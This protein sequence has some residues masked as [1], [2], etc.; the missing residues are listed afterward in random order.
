ME[1]IM[2]QTRPIDK[3]DL[4]DYEARSV[5]GL[6]ADIPSECYRCPGMDFPNCPKNDGNNMKQSRY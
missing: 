4:G 3:T 2:K 6:C 1:A 5:G